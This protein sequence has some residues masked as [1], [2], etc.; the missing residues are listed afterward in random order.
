[1]EILSFY[2]PILD[3]L[4]YERWLFYL[5]RD[6]CTPLLQFICKL[7][8]FYRVVQFKQTSSK[9]TVFFKSYVY[10]LLYYIAACCSQS[11]LKEMATGEYNINQFW[12]NILNK[13]YQSTFAKNNI[14]FGTI[15]I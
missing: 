7:P 8:Y 13:R 15:K 10:E 6:A 4:C 2:L 9:S 5:G 11:K 14:I 12:R 3:S 1:M